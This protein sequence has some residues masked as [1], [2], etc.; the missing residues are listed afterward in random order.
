MHQKNKS[1]KIQWNMIKNKCSNISN[2]K[3]TLKFVNW[4]LMKEKCPKI[5]TNI[6][7]TNNKFSK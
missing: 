4:R 1:G 2:I 7:K 3:C 6:T 5:N